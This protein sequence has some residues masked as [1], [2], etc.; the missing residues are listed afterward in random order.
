MRSIF[1]VKGEPY[2]TTFNRPL[3]LGVCIFF[4]FS[5]LNKNMLVLTDKSVSY[6]KSCQLYLWAQSVYYRCL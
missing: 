2:E 3:W 1:N 4:F 6:F 5:I